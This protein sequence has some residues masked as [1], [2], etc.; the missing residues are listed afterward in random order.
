MPLTK[1][2]ASLLAQR[3]LLSAVAPKTYVRMMMIAT[4]VNLIVLVILLPYL[5]NCF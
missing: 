3:D 5:L 2:V 1:L 4:A